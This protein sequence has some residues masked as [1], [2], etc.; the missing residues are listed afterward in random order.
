M[1]F[2]YPKG[3]RQ[4]GQILLFAQEPSGRTVAAASPLQVAEDLPISGARETT[5]MKVS[6]FT[7]K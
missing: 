2:S 6:K 1:L 4:P 3:L 5:I 7:Q